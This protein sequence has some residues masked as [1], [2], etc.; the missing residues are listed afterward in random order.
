MLIWIGVLL[1]CQ[2]AG[3][4][5]SLALG[6]PVPGPVLGMLILLGALAIRRDVP[7]G[8]TRTAEGFLRYLPLLFVPAAVGAMRSFGVLS[9]EWLPIA[10]AIAGSTVIVMA[11]TG[12]VASLLER[13]A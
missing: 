7:D 3:E 8:L 11:V 2:L 9:R 10:I 1:A 5:I 12:G 4:S 6:L 13:R